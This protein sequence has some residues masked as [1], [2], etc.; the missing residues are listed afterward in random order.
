[1]RMEAGF[2]IPPYRRMG[3]RKPY[4]H[5][6]GRLRPSSSVAPS[7]ILAR[8]MNTNSPGIRQSLRREEASRGRSDLLK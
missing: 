8:Q 4:R 6:A 3:A 7:P 1:M 2:R 5:R